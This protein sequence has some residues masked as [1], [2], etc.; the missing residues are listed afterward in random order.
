MFVRYNEPELI[1]M[2]DRLSKHRRATFAALCA[3]RLLPAYVAFCEQSG[4]GNSEEIRSALERLWRD[5]EGE[6]MTATEIQAS[7][8]VCTALVPDE[9]ERPW[10]SLQPYAMDAVSAVTYAVRAR[11]TGDSQEAAWAARCAYESLDYYVVDL[12][13]IDTSVPGASDRVMAHPL[14]QAELF[15]QRRDLDDLL[16]VEGQDEISVIAKI[17]ERA[18]TDAIVFFGPVS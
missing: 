5:L 1:E 6:Q 13:D 2:L 10:V 11:Q 17:R 18:Q 14:V 12:E 16:R 7:I 15:R 8:D 4:R 9:D 3:E